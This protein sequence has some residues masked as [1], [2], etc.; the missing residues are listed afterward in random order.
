MRVSSV[1]SA[2]RPG[3]SLKPGASSEITSGVKTSATASSTS[4]TATIMVK[5]R[6]ANSFAGSGPSWVRIRA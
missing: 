2:K 1:A 5:T 4:W 6:S 3:S